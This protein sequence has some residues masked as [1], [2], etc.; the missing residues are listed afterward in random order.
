MRDVQRSRTEEQHD[1]APLSR[2]TALGVIGT[3]V[4][5]IGAS[6]IASAGR[7]TNAGPPTESARGPTDVV[8]D[9]EDAGPENL[10]IDSDA[11]IYMSM[12][13]GEVLRLDAERATETGLD[14]SETDEIASFDTGDNG[15]L[16]GVLADDGYLFVAVSSFRADNHGIWKIELDRTRETEGEASKEEGVDQ[17]ISLPHDLEE[18]FTVPNGLLL[19]PDDDDLL[20][21]DSQGA[22]W[23]VRRDGEGGADPWADDD[24]LNPANVGE[25]LSIGANGLA[26]KDCNAVY[27]ANTNFGRIVRVPVEG[28]GSAGEPETHVEDEGL[29]GADGI[30]FDRAG[31][32]IVAVNGQ[33]KVVRVPSAEAEMAVLADEEDGLD[34]PADVLFGTVSQRLLV[35][36]Y[37]PVIPDVYEGEDPSLMRINRT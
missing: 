29:V 33:N 3:G 35:A 23:R 31:R 36:N 5:G 6:P 14:E 1:S 2:R 17:L 32:L 19:H 20:V 22:I 13:S 26:A 21:S 27:V 25:V 10:A 12:E 30:A 11:N 7:H 9:F 15:F 34:F 37:A 8:V 28:D 24:L 4:L 18:D 16:T